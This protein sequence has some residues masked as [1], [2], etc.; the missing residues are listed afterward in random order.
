[1]GQGTRL[2]AV[3]AIA[4]LLAS[5]SPDRH[6]IEGGSVS[7]TPSATPAAITV[8][9]SDYTFD[10]PD[11]MPAG[12]VTVQL[13]NHG[14]ELHQAQLIR[15]EQGKTL[16]DVAQFLKSGGPIPSW[17]KFVGGPNGIAPGQETEAT[18]VLSPGNYAYIC[19]IPSPD[20]SIHAAKGMARPFTVTE[21]SSTGASQ[22]PPA[23]VTIKLLDYDFQPSQPLKAGRQTIMVENAGP[24]PHEVVLL[25]L[26]PGKTTEDF[27]M[28]AEH[29][30]KGPPP[31]QPLGGVTVLDKGGRGSFT[32]DL[33][34]GDYGFIC[35]YPDQKDGKPHLAHGMMKTFKV[36]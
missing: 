8:T 14:K 16:N 23:D 22:I 3:L 36:S 29:G 31:A 26:A 21:A 9:A 7:E 6:K 33:T 2:G 20:G 11:S 17:I 19:L 24:Q 27:G 34:P 5:C 1:M 32:A 10:A 28:W 15:L 30:M 12:A 13:V 25:K 4:A 35:F 18:A